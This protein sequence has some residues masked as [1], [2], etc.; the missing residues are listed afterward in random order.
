VKCTAVLLE[1]GFLSN[2][3]DRD[4]LTS[5]LGQQR[6]AEMILKNMEAK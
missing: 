4:Y 5:Q 6:I 1:L 3:K 2:T